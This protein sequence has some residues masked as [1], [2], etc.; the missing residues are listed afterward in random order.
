MITLRRIYEPA[1]TGEQ[2]R[3][4]VDRLWP[5][6][7]SKE[8]A[9]CNEWLIEISPSNELRKWYGH[10]PAKW[11]EFRLRYKKELIMK[12]DE[13]KRLKGLEEKHGTLTL[14]YSSKEEKYNN[15]VA[16]REL[17]LEQL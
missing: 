15:A 11:E 13:L 8:K 2:Y 7:I 4:L 1:E 14:L 9:G 10:D 3:V 12:Q 17:I 16:L 6:G 5:R